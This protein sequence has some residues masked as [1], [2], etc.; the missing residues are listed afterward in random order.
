MAKTP[1][2]GPSIKSIEQYNE[3]NSQVVGLNSKNLKKHNQ[4]NSTILRKTSG[5][6]HSD[7]GNK[8]TTKTSTTKKGLKIPK[9]LDK[10][11]KGGSE[12][13][14]VHEN[15]DETPKD[16][17][18]AGIYTLIGGLKAD[19]TKLQDQQEAQGGRGETL[20]QTILTMKNL[21]QEALKRS[22][23]TEDDL[24]EIDEELTNSSKNTSDISS[25]NDENLLRNTGTGNR[26]RGGFSPFF[27]P[28]NG[29]NSGQ[30]IIINNSQDSAALIAFLTQTLK[31]IEEKVEKR[32]QEELANLENKRQETKKRAKKAEENAKQLE[33]EKIAAENKAKALTQQ[34]ETQ[35][36]EAENKAEAEKAK[37]ETL[38]KQ[39]EAQKT[40]AENKAKKNEAEKNEAESKL[41]DLEEKIKKDQEAKKAKESWPKRLST[42]ELS[43]YDYLS[44]VEDINSRNNEVFIYQLKGSSDQ[45]PVE[46]HESGLAIVDYKGENAIKALNDHIDDARSFARYR[47]PTMTIAR[48]ENADKSIDHHLIFSSPQH[49]ISTKI[50]SAEVVK[51][52]LKESDI[53]FK[54]SLEATARIR[55]LKEIKHD[56]SLFIDD[57]KSEYEEGSEYANSEYGDDDLEDSQNPEFS[58]KNKEFRKLSRIIANAENSLNSDSTNAWRNWKKPEAALEIFESEIVQ[59]NFN[60]KDLL[61]K[62]KKA[63]LL[64][65]YVTEE[66]VIDFFKEIFAKVKENNNLLNYDNSAFSESG[67]KECLNILSNLFP[68]RSEAIEQLN[69]YS[70][71]AQYSYIVGMEEVNSYEELN[72]EEEIKEITPKEQNKLRKRASYKE[73]D[74]DAKCVDLSYSE[75][76]KEIIK[77][78]NIYNLDFDIRGKK[79]ERFDH[80]LNNVDAWTGRHAGISCR[81]SEGD[82]NIATVTFKGLKNGD[83][84]YEGKKIMYVEILGTE[85]GTKYYVKVELASANKDYPV[86]DGENLKMEKHKT[87]DLIIDKN[88]VYYI[89]KDG[90]HQPKPSKD[91]SDWNKKRYETLSVSAVSM[92]GGERKTSV[93]FEGR[94]TPCVSLA[95]SEKAIDEKASDNENKFDRVL[96]LSDKFDIV[97]KMKRKSDGKWYPEEG[98]TMYLRNLHDKDSNLK[99][100]PVSYKFILFKKDADASKVGAENDKELLDFLQKNG[101]KKEAIQK[102][103][104]QSGLDAE[105]DKTS[106]RAVCKYLESNLKETVIPKS[107]FKPKGRNALKIGSPL[108]SQDDIGIRI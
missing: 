7:D 6:V 36:T 14:S 52:I 66:D 40:E 56:I 11:I 82:E 85:P 5:S 20:E 27:Q 34:L 42:S 71:A 79:K 58:L 98:H 39:L 86:Y 45:K 96:S 47:N 67:R 106:S 29:N 105:K 100:V 77:N 9:N 75:R 12:T 57:N 88:T 104:D 50:V 28:N 63:D 33:K 103:M 83:G 102:L 55:K 108:Q 78:S 70:F 16:D 93:L 97:V 53:E 15:K 44:Y 17:N 64:D 99:E 81:R 38:A 22:V 60:E 54:K 72:I 84:P 107:I 87:G 90:K 35:K 61:E 80:F 2:P 101:V 13:S 92:I 68:N 37:A 69:N 10:K 65:K 95:K 46:L 89:D 51:Q 3:N 91:L 23:I 32:N 31:T 21:L 25:K 73:V 18:L 49:G 24:S 48:I 74:E 1:T 30:P 76:E 26:N 4:N 41:K 62:F 8:L 19:I 43:D 59:N 94:A